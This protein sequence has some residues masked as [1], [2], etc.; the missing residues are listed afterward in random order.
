MFIFIGSISC[1]ATTNMRKGEHTHMLATEGDTP[2]T[3]HC[4]MVFITITLECS[5]VSLIVDVDA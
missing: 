2:S 5:F 1:S 3:L 4:P